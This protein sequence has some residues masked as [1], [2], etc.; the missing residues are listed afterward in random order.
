MSCHDCGNENNDCGCSQEAL[1]ISQVCNP[2]D[3]STEE[4]SESFPS[5][6]I[7]YT[8][9][10][11][12]CNNTTLVT[13]GDNIAQAIA[14]IIAFFCTQDGVD[15]DIVCGN[16]TI[17]T[18]ET[19]MND[20]LDQIVAYFCNAITALTDG[21]LTTVNV[22][23]VN[24][25]DAGEPLCTDSVWTVT[26][27]DAQSNQIDQIQFST[28]TCEPRELCSIILND[29]LGTDSLIL[30]RNG[31]IINASYQTL[32]DAIDVAA[33]TNGGMFAQ[34][35]DSATVVDPTPGSIVNLQDT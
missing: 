18:A 26:F 13:S 32:L 28:R 3:C 19:S 8:G 33:N 20:A 27:L 15:A 5:Q 22:G 4:C 29:P 25:P 31:D 17:V 35:A 2:I 12:I 10:D 30:C 23:V 9:D 7:L 21:A 34:T 16:D 24:T 6:C 1:H 11:I 14:N